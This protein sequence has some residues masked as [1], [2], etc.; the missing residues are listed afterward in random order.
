[1][2]IHAFKISLTMVLTA[3]PMFAFAQEAPTSALA[4][5]DPLLTPP[6]QELEDADD[7]ELTETRQYDRE[8]VELLTSREEIMDAVFEEKWDFE[9]KEPVARF[10]LCAAEPSYVILWSQFSTSK[11]GVEPVYDAEGFLRFS[12][13]NSF[14]FI[15][16]S[17]PYV[18]SWRLDGT[19]M[20]LIADW[21][22]A[23][24]PLR[25]PVERV[26]TPVE[27]VD[28]EGGRNSYVEEMYR[29]GGFRFHRIATTRKG[30]QTAC[31]C[32]NLGN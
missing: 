23:G 27:V 11:E 28:T 20:V 26:M 7:V 32:S 24:E 15:Y 6:S 5:C 8:E 10:E 19:E 18:G 4:L 31:A 3:A 25:A 30:M 16:A 29:I 1:M 2:M 22:R 21:L 13:D 14:E 17:R 12:K 9:T